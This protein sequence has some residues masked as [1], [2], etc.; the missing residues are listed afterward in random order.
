LHEHERDVEAVLITG[1][2]GSGKSSL[3]AEIAD[4][5]EER[6]LPYAAID[7]D[8]LAWADTGRQD[9]SAEHRLLLK[10]LASVMRNYLDAGVRFFVLARAF[11]S[12]SELES[13]IG[14]LPMRPRLVRLTLPADV[15][16]R[17]L[18][19]DVT[20]GRHDD[21][22]E[23]TALVAEAEVEGIEDRTVSNDRPI[24]GAAAEVLEWLDWKGT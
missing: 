21:L 7:L 4:M 24:S 10:N 8:W 2:Y 11:R 14:A 15:I 17:R 22:R 16:E 20:S 19:S 3:A 1:A 9:E 6:G 12:T 5:L 23:L 13:L 18:G